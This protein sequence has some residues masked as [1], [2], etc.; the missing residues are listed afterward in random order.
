[1][2]IY[3]ALNVNTTEAD[4]FAKEKLFIKNVPAIKFLPPGT[5][6]KPYSKIS[7]SN[8]SGLN[9]IH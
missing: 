2:F 7:F 1:M 3:H 8:S 9:S 5:T 6:K 4:T